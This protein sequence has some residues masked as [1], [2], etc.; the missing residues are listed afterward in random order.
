MM[1]RLT[2]VGLMLALTCAAGQP[3]AWKRGKVVGSATNTA[4]YARGSTTTATTTGT[5]S[6]GYG[7]GSTVQANTTA[8]T[9]IRHVQVDTNTLLIVG[10]DYVYTVQDSRRGGGGLLTT[11]IANRKHGC[12]F[13]V[14]DEINYA[15]D[16]RDMHVLDAD[17]KEC[18]L[19]II[20]QEK[21]Q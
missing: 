18:K 11:A 5:V 4:V 17:G 10:D 1:K 2:G 15:Q 13:I 9:T 3:R 20:R 7:A 8:T 12:R 14:G 21:R 6:P 16:K 19:Q